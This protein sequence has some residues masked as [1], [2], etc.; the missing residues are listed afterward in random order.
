MHL[1]TENEKLKNEI[2]NQ[3]TPIKEQPF[4]MI[5]SDSIVE[6][7]TAQLSLVEK[8]RRQVIVENEKLTIQLESL[9]K[10]LKT[11]T[12]EN[13]NFQ[14]TILELNKV[15]INFIIVKFYL[16]VLIFEQYF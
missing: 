5:D 16:V 1:K 10:V 8:Q 14:S 4:E 3:I 7:L 12:N 6:K 9:E 15:S 13:E 11:M 2:A